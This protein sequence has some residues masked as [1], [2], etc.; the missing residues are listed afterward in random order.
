MQAL[1]NDTT[2]GPPGVLRLDNP[3]QTSYDARLPYGL[4][5]LFSFLICFPGFFEFPGEVSAAIVVMVLGIPFWF[6]AMSQRA[7]GVFDKGTNIGLAVI[8]PATLF[9]LFW[10]FTSAI[11]A[12]VPFRAGRSITSFLGAFAVCFMVIGTTTSARTYT[13]VKVICITLA[14]TCAISLVA[15]QEPALRELIF[16][17][18]DR[19]RGFFK[20]PN[21]FGMALSTFLPIVLGYFVVNRGS[22]LLWGTCYIL[23]VTGLLLS[24][25]KMNLLLSAC[26]TGAMLLTLAY[27][28][29]AGAKRAL[30]IA[31]AI[32]SY[33]VLVTFGIMILEILNPRALKILT[34]FF[35]DGEVRS[36][37]AR[38]QLW[39]H[40]V[41]QLVASPFLG[42]GAGQP[43]SLYEGGR[44]I[45][46]S[47]NVFLDIARTLGAPGLVVFCIVV[48]GVVALSVGSFL[49]AVFANEADQRVRVETIALAIGSCAYL[50]ANISSDSMGPSTSVFLWMAFFLC[51]ASRGRLAGPHKD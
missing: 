6:Q 20:N 9:L 22:R 23:F 25:S 27:A 17:F 30:M 31:V 35:S 44:R 11:T 8:L 39:D 16:R 18:S 10:S 21:Q 42:H 15:Y 45:T 1:D 50:A 4:G 32:G 28:L 48:V 51:L 38:A 49:K 37:Q 12:D 47:H 34:D 19:A 24:G 36:L 46:H 29:N 5:L 26:T 41:Q 3:I 40:S 7:T 2:A 14:L 43:L 13:Y 33:A